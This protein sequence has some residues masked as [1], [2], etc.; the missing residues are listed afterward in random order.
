M[1]KQIGITMGD[2]RGIGPEIVARAWHALSDEERS[3]VFIYGDRAALSAAC[4]LTGT[5][6]DQ[7]RIVAT[8]ATTPPIQKVDEQEAA[9]LAIS[10]IDAAAADCKSKKIL[11]I[12]TAPV[13]KRRIQLA[14]SDFVG[15]TEYLAKAANARNPVMMFTATASPENKGGSPV[16]E[17][18]VALVTM[19]V[20]LKDVPPLITTD[21]VLTAIRRA[22]DALGQ[23]F[24]HSSPRI[25]VMSLNPHGGERGS[26][27]A[28]EK[29]AII[30][31]IERALKEGITCV[32]P[33]AAD[34]LFRKMADFD[35]DAVVAMYHDQG[36][37]PMKLLF[38]NRCINLTLGLPYIRTS[39][40]HGT[41]EDIAWLG[42][43]DESGMLDA[44]RLTIKL[45]G[46]IQ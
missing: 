12:V 20:P 42:Q 2:P 43:A 46:R 18:C 39:P 14:V 13:N 28:E 5:E 8:S 26:I 29:T 1:K 30:P 9:R 37:I 6:F 41:A 25:A 19:H 21:R 31:A 44:I 35:F 7:K 15:H 16:L 34:S 32:G 4:E 33:L 23:Y 3:G 40:A 45:V 17:F 24:D 22:Y 36:L 38:Q 10:A 27:G 11:G